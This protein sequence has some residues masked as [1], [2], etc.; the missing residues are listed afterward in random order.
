M[1][2]M[3]SFDW[4]VPSLLT[5]ASEM[6][7]YHFC[8]YANINFYFDVYKCDLINNSNEQKNISLLSWLVTSLSLCNHPCSTN[9]MMLTITKRFAKAVPGFPIWS[10]SHR[11]IG[12]ESLLQ[13][14]NC[15][16]F[17]C[18]QMDTVYCCEF[19]GPLT[20]LTA[21]YSV[22]DLWPQLS[23]LTP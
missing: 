4:T 7:L 5:V 22:V 1:K 16:I 6:N 19:T 20:F 11:K 17:R 18:L 23:S 12:M 14:Y 21:A 10:L 3:P 15:M 2:H 9:T 13:G 8:N